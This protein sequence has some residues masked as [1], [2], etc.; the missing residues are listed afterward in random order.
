MPSRP[1]WRP[2]AVRPPVAPEPR[3][4]SGSSSTN[5][6][7]VL[8]SVGARRH[9][10]PDDEGEMEVTEAERRLADPAI[11]LPRMWNFWPGGVGGIG[12]EGVLDVP[13][14]P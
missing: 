12:E 10:Q 11:L 4:Q 2:R 6:N 8:V 3:G 1:S 9:E 13:A 14:W 5:R 7:L